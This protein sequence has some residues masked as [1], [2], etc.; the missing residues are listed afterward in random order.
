MIKSQLDNL[1]ILPESTLPELAQQRLQAMR[2][3]YRHCAVTRDPPHFKEKLKGAVTELREL[4]VRSSRGLGRGDASTP[5]N[6]AR[7]DQTNAKS[8]QR[9]NLFCLL[10]IWYLMSAT[11]NSAML[12]KGAGSSISIGPMLNSDMT[13]ARPFHDAV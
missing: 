12:V 2:Y 9:R 4:E 13:K 11:G 1:N 6:G 5:R 8:S 3:F 10:Y 7:K